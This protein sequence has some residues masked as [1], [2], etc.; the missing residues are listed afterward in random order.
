MV[1]EELIAAIN[2][3]YSAV[4]ESCLGKIAEKSADGQTYVH[5]LPQQAFFVLLGRVVP[6]YAVASMDGKMEMKEPKESWQE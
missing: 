6:S 4:E 1:K 5:V 2:L 3:C